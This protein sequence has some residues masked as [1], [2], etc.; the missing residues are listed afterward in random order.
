MDFTT[1][2]YEQLLN[3]LIKQGYAFQ[4]FKNFLNNPQIKVVLLR[5]DIDI[6]KL[7][8]LEFAKIQSELGIVGTYYFR[9]VDESFDASVFASV[10]EAIHSLGHE[11]GYHYEDMDFATGNPEIAIEF[12]E[13]HLKQLKHIVPIETICMHD[14]R[15]S[16]HEN[17]DVWKKYNYK[18][19]CI[20]GEPYFDL[21]FNDV[22]Y[23]TD[24]GRR[25]DGFKYSV[26]VKVKSSSRFPVYHSTMDTF[27]RNE[28]GKFPQRAIMNFHPQ[29]WTDKKWLWRKDYLVRSVKNQIK[30][31][32]VR[33]QHD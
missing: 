27:E 24:T 6:R 3:S 15:K 8:S 19:Y 14:S 13:K 17:K 10:I 2:I 18:K 11:I 26:R 9:I 5:H 12:F 25:R 23:Y 30:K 1:K 33:R 22:V 20:P 28:A 32:I 16:K 31:Q 29:R 4:T 7:H 21:D